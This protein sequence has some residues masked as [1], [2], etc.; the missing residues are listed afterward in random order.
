LLAQ[1]LADFLDRHRYGAAFRN[2]YLLP[3]IA[4]IWSCPQDQMLRFPVATLI[5]F[6]H[7]HGLLQVDNRPAWRTVVG[8]SRQY[9]DA[10]VKQLPDVRASTPVLG[11]RRQPSGVLIRTADLTETFDAVVLACHAPQAL[12]LLA[13]GASAMERST[14]GAFRTQRNV[15]VLHTDARLMPVAPRAWAAWNFERAEPSAAVHADGQQVCLH[16]WI[17]K[18]Q[19]LPFGQA[20]MVSLNPLRSPEASKVH[21]EF[22][23]EH[24]VFDAQAIQAQGE[25]AQLQ[26]QQRTWFCGAW[27]GYGF[28]EDG[29]RSGLSAARLLADA[30]RKTSGAVHQ[31]ASGRQAA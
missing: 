8:G 18:L 13:E 14:L 7:N 21:G 19:P 31:P 10:I 25:L 20:V 28:H 15:A 9:V 22:E 12:R 1:P 17:N 26:G 5:R 4:S 16:Y 6:C 11:I 27:C 23:W 29:L 24:P 2:G 30:L 3:M